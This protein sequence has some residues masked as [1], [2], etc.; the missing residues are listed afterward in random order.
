MLVRGKSFSPLNRKV[1]LLF[2][3]TQPVPWQGSTISF[4]RYRSWNFFFSS[5]HHAGISDSS[6]SSLRSA[7]K[8]LKVKL[9]QLPSASLKPQNVS[10]LSLIVLRLSHIRDSITKPDR[11]LEDHRNRPLASSLLLYLTALN[12][13]CNSW[14]SKGSKPRLNVKFIYLSIRFLLLI[15]IQAELPTRRAKRRFANLWVE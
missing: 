6:A 7:P 4:R 1:H 12:K 8:E 11:M 3:E 2:L 9:S 5:S 10:S 14:H 15:S 13:W